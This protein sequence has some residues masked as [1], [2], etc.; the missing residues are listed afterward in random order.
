MCG[1]TDMTGAQRPSGFRAPP[2]PGRD[3]AT[4]FQF[5]HQGL[6]SGGGVGLR[7]GAAQREAGCA[8]LREGGTGGASCPSPTHSLHRKPRVLGTQRPRLRS[9]KPRA[10]QSVRGTEV[11]STLC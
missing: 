2:R 5:P 6:P 11:D 8:G 1:G 7:A 3:V 4:L 9:P 10:G